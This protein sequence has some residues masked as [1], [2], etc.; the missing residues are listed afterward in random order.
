MKILVFILN[1][2]SHKKGRI[3]NNSAF[4]CE[5]LTSDLLLVEE[6]V[7]LFNSDGLLGE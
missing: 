4:S 3:I 6:F 2:F 1:Y 5:L 7:E